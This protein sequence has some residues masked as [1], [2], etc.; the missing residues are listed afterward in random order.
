MGRMTAW[1]ASLFHAVPADEM[2]GAQL[3]GPYWEIAYKGVDHADFFRRLPG[4]SQKE[5]CL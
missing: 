3:E 4:L 5:A 1:L 2:A